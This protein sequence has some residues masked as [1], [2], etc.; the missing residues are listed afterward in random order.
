VKIVDAD[1]PLEQVQK[2]IKQLLQQ[3]ILNIK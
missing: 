2:T 3:H 1:Q